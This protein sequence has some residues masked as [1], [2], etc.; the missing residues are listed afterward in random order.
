M[1]G[2]IKYIL[3][4]LIKRG[5]WF[6]NVFFEGC[7]KMSMY[8]TFNT[9]VINLG[10]T[11]AVHAFNYDGLGLK[12]GNWAMTR[13]PLLGDYAILKNY[14]SFLKKDRSIVIITL[15]PF[16]SLAGS[17]NFLDDRYYTFLYPSTIPMLMIW[18]LNLNGIL[19]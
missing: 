7:R 18:K 12:A 8:S 1:K 16:S 3:N 4:A 17:Y 5:Y 15:C 10:S 6:N 14:S 11:S 9:D 19:H 13:N 2:K